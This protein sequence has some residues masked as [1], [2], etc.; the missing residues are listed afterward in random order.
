MN[1]SVPVM[2]CAKAIGSIIRPLDD[3]EGE[4]CDEPNEMD[5]KL[6]Q[7]SR[8]VSIMRVWSCLMRTFKIHTLASE[9]FV[10]T[11]LNKSTDEIQNSWNAATA[12]V[13]RRLISGCTANRSTWNSWSVMEED[14]P[15]ME[16]ETVSDDLVMSRFGVANIEVS[17]DRVFEHGQDRP[18][19]VPGV[20]VGAPIVEVLAMVVPFMNVVPTSNIVAC[21]CNAVPSLISVRRKSTKRALHPR[22]TRN[23]CLRLCRRG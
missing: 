21:L 23:S 15:G 19:S 3:A 22:P 4:N 12:S 16:D 17:E 7:M 10:S 18:R 9:S 13:W 11:T 6:E 14:E 5:P 2:F 1:D 20:E 8:C